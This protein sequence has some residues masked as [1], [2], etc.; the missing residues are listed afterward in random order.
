MNDYCLLLLLLIIVNDL[1][2][3]GKNK[4]KIRMIQDKLST[5]FAMKDLGEVK[6][7]LGINIVYDYKEHKMTLDQSEYIESLAR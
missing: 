4:S 6:T 2:I 3:C 1:L 7:Y 5:R